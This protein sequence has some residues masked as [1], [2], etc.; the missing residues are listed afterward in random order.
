MIRCKTVAPSISYLPTPLEKINNTFA[1]D[2]QNTSFFTVRIDNETVEQGQSVKHSFPLHD[3]DLYD[4]WGVHYNI[5]LTQSV[6]YEHKEKIQITDRQQTIVIANPVQNERVT[7]T[8]IIVKNASQ[9]SIQITNGLGT[10]FACCLD[11]CINSREAKPE[12]N[13]A[14]DKTVVYEI[15]KPLEALASIK[16][17]VSV[18][19]TN[20]PLTD[21]TR[22][23]PGYVYTYI[24]DGKQ[25]VKEDE[26]PLLTMNEP[27][28][29]K[30]YTSTEIAAVFSGEDKKDCYVLGKENKKDQYGVQY[31]AAYISCI[32]SKGSEKWQ[33]VFTETG[34]DASF[35]AGVV[36]HNGAVL[37]VGSHTKNTHSGLIVQYA[38]DGTVVQSQK[39]ECFAVFDSVIKKDEQNFLLT[40]FAANGSFLTA[41][42]AIE[43]NRLQCI[44]HTYPIPLSRNEAV[45]KAIPFYDEQSKMLF[46]FCNLIDWETEQILPAMVCTISE[47]GTSNRISLQNTVQTV[48]SVVRDS[49]GLFYIGGE[50]VI[51]EQST[52]AVVCFDY[53]QKNAEVFY[54]DG[55]PYSYITAVNLNE[56]SNELIISGTVN[57]ADSFGNGGTPFMKSFDTG[58]GKEL[59]K[60]IHQNKKYELLS[61]FVPCA[62][63]GFIAAYS[64][65]SEDGNYTA[66]TCVLRLNAV[67]KSNT[68]TNSVQKRKFSNR[69][70]EK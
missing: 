11:G 14:P 19:R 61:S 54:T 26:R 59:W 42:L 57:A 67:G 70:T 2:I 38:Q 32:N 41:K 16:V 65:I 48:S 39:V 47:D 35:Y 24:F 15:L 53:T 27:L 43:N 50:T 33:H 30:P 34:S 37:A 60:T 49:T 6:F 7:E 64:A 8:Y 56:K 46:L 66:P 4:G 51:Q 62:D 44:P 21:N 5:P 45:S 12:Y 25:V 1:A 31:E 52:A 40:G 36:L 55:F 23:H 69:V 18:G 68:N 20:Y 17:C 58:S 3:S 29:S 10:I 63:Y 9:Q 28:W 22:F 13:T